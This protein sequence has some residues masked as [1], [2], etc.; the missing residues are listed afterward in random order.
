MDDSCA[1]FEQAV[2][3]DW[4]LEFCEMCLKTGHDCAKIFKKGVKQDQQPRKRRPPSVKRIW[5]T[6]EAT[7]ASTSEESQKQ[8]EESSKEVEFANNEVQDFSDCVHVLNLN[9]LPRKGD[10]YTLSNKKQSV[11]RV[12]SK[13]D[14]AI[15]NDDWMQ[16]Y[17]YMKVEYRLPFISD[18]AL[19]VITMK[20]VEPSGK[21]LFRFFN[22]WIDY[23]NFLALVEEALRLLSKQLKD[24]EFRGIKERLKQTRNKLQRIQDQMLSCY[25]DE[26]VAEEKQLLENLE[27]LSLI[28]ESILQQKSRAK[29]I[30]LE[31]ANSK[32]QKVIASIISDTQAGFILG[33]NVADNVLLAHELVKAYSRKNISPR[34][35]IKVDIQK[36]LSRNLKTLK[37]EKAFHYHPMCSRLDLTHLS[38]ADDLLLFVRGDATSVALLHDRFNIFSGASGL[39]ANLAKSSIYYGG[40]NLEVKHNIH[41][42]QGYSQGS[43]P[44]R[45]LGIPL[46]TK[47]LFVMQWKPLINKTVARI[48]SWTTK[49]LSYAGRI[50]LVQHVIF[51]IQVYWSQIFIIPV[52]VVEAIETYCRSYVRSGENI[53]TKKA[54]AARDRMCA[55][56]ATGGLNLINLALWNKAA[57]TKTCWELANKK[58][59]LWIK[60]INSY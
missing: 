46:D 14:R 12:Y 49:K 55:P 18:H 30:R 17:G 7:M 19:I 24:T 22:V 6:K 29:W 40:V 48:S 4:K 54:L 26:L 32:I 15:E 2:K 13:F 28:E 50:Q 10:F 20:R 44:F 41:Q 39:K 57:I 47:K 43:L 36:Y 21:I 51:D 59:K 5:K 9:E 11:D 52:K 34:C 31:Y 1:I 35:L 45:Y 56:K 38:F 37:H 16:T 25:S 53:I 23:P 3:Y 58:D 33:R 8:V 60:W 27:K 42:K